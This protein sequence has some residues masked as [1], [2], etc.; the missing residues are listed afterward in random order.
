MKRREFIAEFDFKGEPLHT[1]NVDAHAK[2]APRAGR[3]SES[4]EVTMTKVDREYSL[5]ARAVVAVL[6][7]ALGLLSGAGVASWFVPY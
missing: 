5:P 6:V 2:F 7:F 4:Y 3:L 1:S